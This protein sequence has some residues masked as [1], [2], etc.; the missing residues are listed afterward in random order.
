VIG[1]GP[2]MPKIRAKAGSNV[3][4]LGY[5]PAHELREHL[6]RARA[7]IFAAVED[8]GIAPLEAQA[9]GT[10]VIALGR[11]AATETIVTTGSAPS[12]ALFADQTAEAIVDGVR[13]FEE[14]ESRITAAAC[15]SNAERFAPERFRREFRRY[16]ET[17]LE[18]I[19]SVE[20]SSNS[21]A[22][23]SQLLGDD[24]DGEQTRHQ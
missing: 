22:T 21:A 10:P 8:F 24:D 13:R 15:R 19:R 16:V 11:G 12:G 17:E 18:R 20:S 5:Q 3:R 2:E 4:L 1:D 23:P 7:F 9:C 6:R 14:Q